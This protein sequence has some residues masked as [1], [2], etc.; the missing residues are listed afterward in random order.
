MKKNYQDDN[1]LENLESLYNQ[2]VFLNLQ[3]E[4]NYMEQ[5]THTEKLFVNK[6]NEINSL[7]NYIFTLNSKLSNMINI[8]QIEKY[9]DYTYNKVM[10]SQPKINEILENI[11]DMK[12]NINFGLDRMQLE[13]NLV[14]DEQLFGANLKLLTSNVEKFNSQNGNRSE[15]IEEVKEMYIKYLAQLSDLKQ[16]LKEL[17]NIFKKT[18]ERELNLKLEK[19]SV[20]MMEENEVIFRKLIDNHISPI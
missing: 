5:K 2:M 10:S 3:L 8:S 6:I 17:S 15:L 11:D 18:K 7:R 9:L 14:C 4:S 20:D 13:D 19:L 12:L 1:R 16:L